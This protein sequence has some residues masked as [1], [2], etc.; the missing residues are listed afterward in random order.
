MMFYG[1]YQS[2]T[3]NNDE[4]HFGTEYSYDNTFFL[5]GGY[6]YSD[7]DAYL[8]GFTFGG[9]LVLTWGET[10]LSFDYAWTETD[11]FDANQ[12]FTVKVAF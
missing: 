9:G 11:I 8:Y 7:Q 2:N 3:F 6:T 12:Y 1:S 4:G 5:R 10:D